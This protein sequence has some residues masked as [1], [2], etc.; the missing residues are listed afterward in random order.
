MSSP[1][2]WFSE[3]AALEV[4]CVL[5]CPSVRRYD[6]DPLAEKVQLVGTPDLV[7]GPLKGGTAPEDFYIDVAQ[8]SGDHFV[9]P[10]ALH[11]SGLMREQLQRSY[12]DTV[13]KKIKKY[14]TD[15]N[16][17]MFGL[18][19][20]FSQVGEK[21]EHEL[22]AAE[23]AALVLAGIIGLDRVPEPE[24]AFE[25]LKMVIRGGGHLFLRAAPITY[26][27]AFFLWAV[28]RANGLPDAFL[29]INSRI[30]EA[31]VEG[32][33]VDSWLRQWIEFTATGGRSPAPT[34]VPIP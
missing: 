5:G 4:L 7:A 13:E 30:L 24:R 20:G 18:V 22:K 28:K 21:D 16:S 12:L 6:G 1:E 15:R 3:Q 27:L 2:A 14:A 23:E 11:P 31:G 17:L 33:P 10:K 26:D 9:N 8:P 29:F 25:E 32:H 34:P 19:W